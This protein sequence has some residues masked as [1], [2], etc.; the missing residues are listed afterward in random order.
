[1]PEAEQPSFAGPADIVP[2]HEAKVES[3]ADE[4]GIAELRSL[5]LGPTEKQALLEANDTS[6]RAKLLI[7]FLEMG[8]FGPASET[9]PTKAH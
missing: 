6:A 8:A 7:A 3:P 5:L 1:M 9:P 2:D 4:E